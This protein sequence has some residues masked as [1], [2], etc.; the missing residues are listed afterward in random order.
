MVETKD[1]CEANDKSI[2]NIVGSSTGKHANEV[3][4][5]KYYQRIV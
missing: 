1:N 3:L 2:I 5:T 4:E